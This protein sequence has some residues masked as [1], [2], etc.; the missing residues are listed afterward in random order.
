LF[1]RIGFFEAIVKIEAAHLQLTV[2]IKLHRRWLF[3]ANLARKKGKGVLM[4]KI[5]VLDHGYVELVECG[6]GAAIVDRPG[7]AP[8][9]R[10]RCR[11]RSI[12]SR[13]RMGQQRGGR[14]II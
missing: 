5:G 11:A 6:R 10:K 4:A 2:S 3:S 14:R 1:A 12:S 13:C 9:A 8:M 7:S